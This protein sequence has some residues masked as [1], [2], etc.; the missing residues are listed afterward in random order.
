MERV[1]CLLETAMF[2]AVL[3]DR[4]HVKKTEVLHVILVGFFR[5][6]IPVVPPAGAVFTLGLLA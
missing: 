1:L 4:T 2:N 6:E 5:L 3:K